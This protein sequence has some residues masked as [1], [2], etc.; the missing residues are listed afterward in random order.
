MLSYKHKRSQTCIQVASLEGQDKMS[1]V[2]AHLV[3]SR[4]FS[5]ARGKLGGLILCATA[6]SR[7]SGPLRERNGSRSQYEIQEEYLL[8]IR[9]CASEVE[10]CFDGI[11]FR[12]TRVKLPVDSARNVR[13]GFSSACLD[14][15]AAANLQ[16]HTQRPN[17]PWPTYATFRRCVA[18]F[19]HQHQASHNSTPSRQP[20]Q[21]R[22]A[23]LLPSSECP[24]RKL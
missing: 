12:M 17:A 22:A 4:Q 11:G 21:V 13:E 6:H 5:G 1:L 8:Q 15:S 18:R 16:D 10:R 19:P 2:C 7:I 9:G 23:L 3:L 24:S 20:A 14:C